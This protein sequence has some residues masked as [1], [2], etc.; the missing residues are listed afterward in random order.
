VF[1]AL[2]VTVL[3]VAVEVELAVPGLRGGMV[4]HPA[5]RTVVSEDRT[6][7]VRDHEIILL[8]HELVTDT[9]KTSNH[10]VS[11]HALDTLA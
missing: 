3:D 5:L 8:S 6:R 11:C 1:V 7:R 2:H 9:A 10:L 4:T